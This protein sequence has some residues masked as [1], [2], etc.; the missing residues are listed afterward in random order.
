MTKSLRGDRSWN[1][2]TAGYGS[3]AIAP[4]PTGSSP[5]S[6]VAKL[7]H[8]KIIMIIIYS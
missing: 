1:R 7:T 3:E 5:N 8:T 4:E 6:G 2:A